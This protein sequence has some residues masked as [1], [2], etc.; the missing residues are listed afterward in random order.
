MI[1]LIGGETLNDEKNIEKNYSYYEDEFRYDVIFSVKT[2]FANFNVQMNNAENEVSDKL[3]YLSLLPETL[4]EPFEVW[5]SFEKEID[6]GRVLLFMRI[7]KGI[8]LDDGDVVMIAEA[9]AM[10]GK[11]FVV[12]CYVFPGDATEDIHRYRSGRLIYSRSV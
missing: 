5:R 7:L 1:M 3:R 4:E 2:F 8:E 6:T 11:W 10:E 9:E 12:N